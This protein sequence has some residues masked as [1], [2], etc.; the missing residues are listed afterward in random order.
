MPKKAKPTTQSHSCK[1]KIF[2]GRER[3]HGPDGSRLKIELELNRKN[4]LALAAKI[5]R[6]MT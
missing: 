3:P 4:S 2:G 1:L 6:L 5:V